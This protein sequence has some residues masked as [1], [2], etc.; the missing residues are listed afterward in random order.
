MPYSL[1]LVHLIPFWLFWADIECMVHVALPKRPINQFEPVEQSI[2]HG[3]SEL[4]LHICVYFRIAPI[5]SSYSISP[6]TFYFKKISRY[7][8]T[9]YV[10]SDFVAF[11]LPSNICIF[12]TVW[13]WH[14]TNTMQ[15]VLS[16]S[17]AKKGKEIANTFPSLLS[18]KLPT[19]SY[20]KTKTIDDL[21][22]FIFV[23]VGCLQ[24]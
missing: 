15:M 4:T 11:M 22:S 5:K 9:L 24:V 7:L 23:K 17:D 6:K 12:L 2:R 16:N 20:Q 3:H 14:L 19:F 8:A 21:Q 18:T 1:A 10:F 13:K